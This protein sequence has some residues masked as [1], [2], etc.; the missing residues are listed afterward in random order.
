MQKIM[1]WISIHKR[2]I[3]FVS[4]LVTSAL[5]VYWY[6]SGILTDEIKMRHMLDSTGIFAPIFFI[7]VQ[8]VQVIIPILPGAVGCAFGVAFFGAVK[9]FL[10]NYIGICI[11]SICAF[12]IARAYGQN[13]VKSITSKRFFQKY[14]R[15]LT[16]KNRFE[17]LFSLLIFLPVAP[18][19]FLCYLA[20]ISSMSFRK[21]TLIILLGKPAAIL[22]YSMGLYKIFQFIPLF[23][24]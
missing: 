10:Y 16:D 3:C 14:N 8:A 19:D 2:I 1:E 22:L 4:L 13:F 18:D 5:S 21:F 12:L 6:K 15:Y 7:I 24:K 23:I 11:G 9:G 20:G 17:K